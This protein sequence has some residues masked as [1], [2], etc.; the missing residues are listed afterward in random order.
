MEKAN[1]LVTRFTSP[2]SS[3]ICAVGVTRLVTPSTSVRDRGPS[4]NIKSRESSLVLHL[5]SFRQSSS[6]LLF[7]R[8][9]YAVFQRV[10]KCICIKTCCGEVIWGFV[11]RIGSFQYPPL[12]QYQLCQDLISLQCPLKKSCPLELG[13]VPVL[14]TLNFFLHN[15]TVVVLNAWLHFI[16]HGFEPS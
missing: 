7:Q 12:R 9:E 10:L 2:F 6:S 13:P 4:G 1:L 14:E 15:C 8:I 5:D 3:I 16:L 11:S